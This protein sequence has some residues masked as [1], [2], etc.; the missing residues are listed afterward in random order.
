MPHHPS[1]AT[2]RGSSLMFVSALV[3]VALT[4]ILGTQAAG[5]SSK[6][7]AKAA[8]AEAKARLI[9]QSQLSGRWTA[10][11]YGAGSSGGGPGWSDRSTNNSQCE[12]GPGA[13]ENPYFV[14]GNYFD[15]KGTSAEIQEE[16]DVYPNSAAAAKDVASTTSTSF[17]SCLSSYLSQQKNSIA[18]GIGKGATVEQYVD[19][20][21]R[22]NIRSKECWASSDH[23]HQL[24]RRNHRSLPRQ[25]RDL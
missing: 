10:S 7:N 2:S 12:G 17:Q 21:S 16:V 19:A 25:H 6:Q 8:Y 11:S 14:E 9:S 4:G 1:S 24:R 5:A 3:A 18:S 22:R 13:D 23:S 15:Q 20:N